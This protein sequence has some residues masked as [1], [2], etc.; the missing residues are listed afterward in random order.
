[1]ANRQWSSFR[2][3]FEPRFAYLSLNQNTGLELSPSLLADVFA[4]ATFLNAFSAILAGLFSN[5]VANKYG[6]VGPFNA[7]MLCR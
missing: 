3:R 4:Q 6:A 7:G 1:M 2:V 5:A